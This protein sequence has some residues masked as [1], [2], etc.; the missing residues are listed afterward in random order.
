MLQGQLLPYGSEYDG[1]K[2]GLM[3]NSIEKGRKVEV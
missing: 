3:R 2:A 1:T